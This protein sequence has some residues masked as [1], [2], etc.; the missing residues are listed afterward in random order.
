M[1]KLRGSTFHG[2]LQLAGRCGNSLTVSA[3]RSGA[4]ET[5][6]CGSSSGRRIFVSERRTLQRRGFSRG[7]HSRGS[8]SHF[9]QCRQELGQILCWNTL[10]SLLTCAMARRSLLAVRSGEALFG[11]R[12]PAESSCVWNRSVLQNGIQ[13]LLRGFA[14]GRLGQQDEAGLDRT[15]PIQAMVAPPSGI[16]IETRPRLLV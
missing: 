4:V 12:S 10:V 13:C 6:R 14:F 15:Y 8:A 1:E 9:G 16:R 5:S 7:K 3:Q 11:S 2:C